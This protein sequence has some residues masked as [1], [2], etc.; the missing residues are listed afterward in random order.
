MHKSLLLTALIV[1]GAS[2]S[3]SA[4][5]H[6]SHQVVV[7]V[8]EFQW[9]GGALSAF[10]TA[11]PWPASPD[12]DVSSR[13]SIVHAF[14]GQ[15]YVLGIDDHVVDL[16]ALPSLKLVQSFSISD[17]VAPRD[18]V[19]VGS[20]MALI[21]DHDSAH[22]WWLDTW[23]GDV[24][25]GP[26]LSAYADGDRL[27]DVTRMLLVGQ[28]VFVQMQRYDRDD[29]F[30]EQGA[31]LAVLGPAFNP[32]EPAVLE[33][34][35]DL[36]GTRPDHRMHTNAAG[37]LLWVSAAGVPND[38]WNLDRGIEEIDL[39]TRTSIGFVI[40]EDE[41]GGD[42]GG[43]VMLDDD[44]GFAM[45]HTSIIASTHLRVFNRNVGQIA[46]LHMYAGHID[47]IALDRV[48]RQVLYPV[49]ENG[50]PSNPNPSGGVMI[51]DADNNTQL[52]GFIDLGGQPHDLCVIQ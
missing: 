6:P 24:K 18:L 11:T 28:H 27:P 35:I 50:L 25:P 33:D 39:A 21:S 1:A 22:L 23:T 20:R 30:S 44:K 41:F 14:Y 42:L 17:V 12:I 10:E 31:K 34:V 9:S 40:T 4:Q 51:W 5:I 45:V 48:R 38:W 47:V 26:D 3:A 15:L 7:A 2:Q 29:N 32:L 36:S 52:S 37:T 13:N 49:I 8:N 19:M 43:F 46:E 16:R